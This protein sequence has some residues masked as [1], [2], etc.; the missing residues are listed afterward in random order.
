MTQRVRQN[1]K[2]QID[3]SITSGM[4]PKT[5]KS[6][7]GLVLPTGVRHRTIID[8]SGV[9]AAGKY[10]YDKI[11]QDAPSSF[12]TQDAF[13]KGRSQYISLLDGTKKKVSTWDNVKNEWK[14]TQLGI[15]LA[16]TCECPS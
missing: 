8:K 10:Y 7:V 11:G 12:Y 16:C 4:V 13:R 1:V 14:L 2:A 6:G 3:A 5:P 9:T 15:K